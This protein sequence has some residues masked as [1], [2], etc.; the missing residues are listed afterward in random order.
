MVSVAPDGTV[1][2]DVTAYYSEGLRPIGQLPAGPRGATARFRQTFKAAGPD[3]VLT[4][5][6]REDGRRWVATFPGSDHLVMT[7]R[8]KG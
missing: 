6:M 4:A 3:R 7:R 1:V 8:P 5:V 2:R